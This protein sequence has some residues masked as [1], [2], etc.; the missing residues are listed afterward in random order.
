MWWLARRDNLGEAL[1]T[2]SFENAELA[3]ARRFLK[4]GMVVLDVGAHHGLYTLLASKLVGKDGKV[5]AFEPSSRERR[6]LRLHL[7]LNR[8]GNVAVQPVAVA[9]SDG[10]SEFHVVDGSET[11]CNSLKPPNVASGTSPT[12][13]RAVSLDSW[14][15][16]ENVSTVDFIKLDVEG[17]ELEALEGASLLLERRPRPM[18][19]VEVQDVR[20]AP[21]GYRAKEIVSLLESKGFV[22]FELLRDGSR[23]RLETNG[24]VFDG[25]FAACPDEL[26]GQMEDGV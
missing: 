4:S 3:F 14:M 17:A 23:K 10:E 18:A 24:D 6:A 11:G 25:N 12:T 7:A 9:R 22:W 16:R 15:Q 5:Y 2:G 21:W 8:C 1:L 20:T 19:V 26:L 13:V